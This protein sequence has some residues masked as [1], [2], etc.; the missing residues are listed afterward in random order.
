MS[1]SAAFEGGLDVSRTTVDSPYPSRYV[2]LRFLRRV[3]LKAQEYL[4]AYLPLRDRKRL[5]SPDARSVASSTARSSSAS[6]GI[7]GR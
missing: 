3:A 2:Q 4:L 1:F 7:T 6:A 5:F